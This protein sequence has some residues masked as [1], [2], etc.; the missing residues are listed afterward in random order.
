M[1]FKKLFIVSFL[2]FGSLFA[3]EKIEKQTKTYINFEIVN[4]KLG[5]IGFGCREIINGHS[6]DWNIAV[7]NFY[8]IEHYGR[9]F[10][11]GISMNY[12]YFL[13]IN[14]YFGIGG[15]LKADFS[16]NHFTPIEF[17]PCLTWG[18]LTKVKDNG[19]FIELKTHL[20]RFVKIL[21]DYYN[22][23]YDKNYKKE[24]LKSYYFSI[25]FGTYF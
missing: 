21:S 24:L 8:N 19:M 4:S 2:V 23:D 12:L 18:F 22:M 15:R 6:F 7:G 25:N 13:P 5:W 9:F 11:L 17:N 20:V 14:T 16:K 3:E 10:P 1:K